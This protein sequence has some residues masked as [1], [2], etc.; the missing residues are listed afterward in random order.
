[1]NPTIDRMLELTADIADELLKIKDSGCNALPAELKLNIISLAEIASGTPD[2]A[3]EPEPIPEPIPEPA[4][5][6][7]PIRE[8]ESVPESEPVTSTEE[9]E[10]TTIAEV[11][12][13]AEFEEEE[14]ADINPEPEPESIQ[15]PTP[16]PEPEPEPVS[17]PKPETASEPQSV[18]APET[19]SEPD[20]ESKPET[21]PISETVSEPQP[22][23]ENKAFRIA[24]A[25][26][27]QAFSINDAFLFRREIFGGSKE[28]FDEALAHMANL[29]SRRA[30]QEYLVEDLGLNLNE[31]PGREFYDTL[32]VFF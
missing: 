31:S 29:N 30:L 11:A 26:L 2:A 10:E 28:S 1:M 9:V 24:P 12:A 20:T 22:E 15:L 14:D 8:S 6:P 23:P 17:E 27:R 13:S 32:E 21:M 16:E 25:A 7:E 19:V 5:E 4:P 3:P 18:P